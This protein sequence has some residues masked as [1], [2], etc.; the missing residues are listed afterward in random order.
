MSHSMQSG[1]FSDLR[2]LLAEKQFATACTNRER[3]DGPI[4]SNPNEES[5]ALNPLNTKMN[6][7]QV[8]SHAKPVEE[9][10]ESF[11]KNMVAQSINKID[12]LTKKNYLPAVPYL[13]DVPSSNAYTREFPVENQA[14]RSPFEQHEIVPCQYMTMVMNGSRG[15]LRVRGEW[16]DEI[17]AKAPGSGSQSARSGTATPRSERD[18][19]KPRIKMSLSDYRS[20]KKP[21]STSLNG[22][23]GLTGSTSGGRSSHNGFNKYVSIPFYVRLQILI[24]SQFYWVQRFPTSRRYSEDDRSDSCTEWCYI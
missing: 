12:E 24:I 2:R 3:P 9:E 14:D 4:V 17:N 23:A 22:T 8:N 10:T 21:S 20:G 7:I 18:P 5:H 16:E 19:N 1:A 6:A 15:V 11:A 13:V